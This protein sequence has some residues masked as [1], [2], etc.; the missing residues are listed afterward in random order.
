[1]YLV[2]TEHKNN[3]VDRGGQTNQQPDANHLADYQDTPL[4]CVAVMSSLCVCL[5]V[6]TVQRNYFETL[7]GDVTFLTLFA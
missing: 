1:M 5:Y 3:T 6:H 4:H 7:L 2:F